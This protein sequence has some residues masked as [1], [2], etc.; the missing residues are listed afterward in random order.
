MKK[1]IFKQHPVISFFLFL[2][3]AITIGLLA[4]YISEVNELSRKIDC[5]DITVGLENGHQEQLVAMYQ[6][7]MDN[8]E[9]YF[10][11]LLGSL[12]AFATLIIGS[13]IIYNFLLAKK[14]FEARLVKANEI[15]DKKINDTRDDLAKAISSTRYNLN[16]TI[17]NTQHNVHRAKFYSEILAWQNESSKKNY[18][19]AFSFIIKALENAVEIIEDFRIGEAIDYSIKTLK[20]IQKKNEQLSISENMITRYR[21]AIDIVLKTGTFNCEK[22]ERVYTNEQLKK[23]AQEAKDLF[24]KLIKDLKSDK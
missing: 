17:E 8:Q 23:K 6:R 18:S 9:S 5:I 16:K 15:F 12:G 3:I 11:W 19:I 2:G 13:M 24:E 14:E 20:K 7:L 4:Y 21:D 10:N 22:E 1:N